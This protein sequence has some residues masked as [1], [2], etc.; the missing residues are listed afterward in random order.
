M[1]SGSPSTPI[2][3]EL[4]MP[5]APKVNEEVKVDLKI[6]TTE[7]ARNINAG[8][9]VPEGAEVVSGQ[10]KEVFDLNAGQ[11]ASISATV[12]FSRPGEYAVNG[13]ALSDQGGGTV[14]GDLATIYL[15]IGDQS[16]SFGQTTNPGG[17]AGSAGGGGAGGGIGEIPTQTD[18]L[19]PPAGQPGCLPP[20]TEL[21]KVSECP[22]PHSEPA[23]PLS[24]AL[25]VPQ[26]AR[27]NEA[28]TGTVTVCST[29]DARQTQVTIELPQGVKLA[30][31]DPGW[32]ADLTANK[33]VTYTLLF[34]FAS[35]GDYQLT[36]AAL[37][38]LAE[39]TVWGDSTTAPIRVAP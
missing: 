1:A 6:S 4:S 27:V 32:I 34:S 10:A 37:Y 11:S 31:G 23:T 29:Q 14:W 33:P 9:V 17:A 26:T 39:G 5:F 13:Q 28:V 7:A 21:P 15:T 8:I 19:N 2:H 35:A 20:P 22:P 36:A 16:S 12:R 38:K 3:V 18:C 25:D 24:V 30:Q